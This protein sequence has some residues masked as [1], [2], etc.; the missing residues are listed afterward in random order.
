MPTGT[1]AIQTKVLRTMATPNTDVSFCLALSPRYLFVRSEIVRAVCTKARLNAFAQT[2]SI[3][4]LD[5]RVT[6][7]TV[8]PPVFIARPASQQLDLLELTERWVATD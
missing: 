7:S 5:D 8:E 4:S 3:Y 2:P 6:A 1:V